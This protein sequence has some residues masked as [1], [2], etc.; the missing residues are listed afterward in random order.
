MYYNSS[1]QGLLRCER[2]FEIEIKLLQ[3]SL[4][5]EPFGNTKKF[6]VDFKIAYRK[7]KKSLLLTVKSFVLLS[8]FFYEWR[9]T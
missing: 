3:S 4:V 7:F 2:H 6:V 9:T 1:I 8:I 5:D